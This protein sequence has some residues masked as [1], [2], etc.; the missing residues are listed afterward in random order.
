MLLPLLLH[1]SR[2]FGQGNVLLLP[3]VSM[4]LLWSLLVSLL[5]SRERER[6]R[7]RGVVVVVWRR[8]AGAN[9]KGFS[10]K[11]HEHK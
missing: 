6:E 9:K 2:C 8:R 10:D 3:P 4:L 7:K 5:S 11:Q 1:S